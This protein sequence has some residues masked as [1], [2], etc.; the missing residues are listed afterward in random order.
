MAARFHSPHRR[1]DLSMTMPEDGI[2]LN[3]SL[4]RATSTADHA[5]HHPFGGM[6]IARAEEDVDLSQ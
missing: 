1:H 4:P 3:Q 2:D 5:M 6:A